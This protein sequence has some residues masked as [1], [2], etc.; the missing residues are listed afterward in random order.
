MKII[1]FNK[2]KTGTV[3]RAVSFERLGKH[4]LTYEVK[5]ANGEWDL[6]DGADLRHA[7][8]FKNG[9]HVKYLEVYRGRRD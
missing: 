8:Y 4:H 7:L 1:D 2:P 5:W 6:V 9:T 3:I